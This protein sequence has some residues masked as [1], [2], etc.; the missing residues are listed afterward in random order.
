LLGGRIA[1]IGGAR[2]A[3]LPKPRSTGNTMV[4]IEECLAPRVCSNKFHQI[5]CCGLPGKAAEGWIRLNGII[6]ELYLDALEI[7][8]CG[9]GD[10][11]LFVYGVV[12][13]GF[14]EEEEGQGGNICRPSFNSKGE[15]PTTEEK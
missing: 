9:C 7:E 1:L 3:V 8:G 4:F 15:T 14:R 5:A 10:G 11:G 13:V 6:E 12:I 2:E